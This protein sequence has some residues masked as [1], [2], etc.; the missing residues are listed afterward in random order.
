M[1]KRANRHKFAYLLLGVA[2]LGL[3]A[4]SP[5]RADVINDKVAAAAKAVESKVITWRRDIHQHPELSNREVRT[6]KLVADHLKALKFDEVKTGVAHTGVIG[7]LKG[8]KPGPVVALRAD[9]DALPVT[10]QV[11]L[12]FASK[13]RSTYNGQDVGVMHAC[14]HDAHT[15]ILMGVAEVLA[16]MRADL[17]GTVVFVFQ[18]AEEGPPQGEEG[19]AK[20]LIK[21][22]VFPGT[23]APQAIFGLHVWPAE[24]GTIGYRP[25]G[26]MAAS[27]ELSIVIQGRQT[28]GSSPWLGVDPIT[29]AGQMVTAIQMIPSRQLDITKAPSVITIGHID[30]GVR[31]NIIPDTVKMDGTIRTF[32][33]DIRK[34]LLADLERTVRTVAEAGGGTAKL[35]IRPYSPVVYNDPDLVARTLPALQRAAGENKVAEQPVIMGAE[36]FAFYQEQIPGFFFFLGINKDGVKAGEAAANHSPLFYVNEDA[37]LVGVKALSYAAVDY[38][39]GAPAP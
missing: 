31:H 1:L 32:D 20:L 18:P 34:K 5:V 36:D 16:G 22:G 19:G 30:G 10:E 26:T 7:V 17:P 3:M 33:T 39:R 4:A 27:D 23:P 29:I 38:L 12:P 28:H 35:E 9:M 2:A 6:A 15:S 11:D 8:G 37:L 25:K 14:G 24:G 13:V 21:E